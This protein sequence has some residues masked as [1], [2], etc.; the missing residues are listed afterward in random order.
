ML[1]EGIC[2]A[3]RSVLVTVL[4]AGA[5]PVSAATVAERFGL[6]RREADVALQLVEGRSN[7]DIATALEISTHTARHHTESVLVKLGV[8]SRAQVGAAVRASV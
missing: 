8:K 4:R 5:E 1:P 2:G 6:T 7:A 3:G